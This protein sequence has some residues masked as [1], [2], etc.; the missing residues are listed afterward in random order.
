MKKIIQ[1]QKGIILDNNSK[2]A[3]E[4]NTIRGQSFKLASLNFDGFEVVMV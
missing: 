4:K 2:S 1:N 3:K